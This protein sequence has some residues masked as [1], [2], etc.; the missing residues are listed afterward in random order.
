M[1]R[2]KWSSL[3]ENECGPSLPQAVVA[4]GSALVMLLI[5]Q[6]ELPPPPLP[7]PAGCRPAQ[8]KTERVPTT[9]LVTLVSTDWGMSWQYRSSVALAPPENTARV[10]S[11]GGD[12]P[13]CAPV[14]PKDDVCASAAPRTCVRATC[15]PT[16]KAC[17]VCDRG[18][19]V[20]GEVRYI[21][22]YPPVLVGEG[23][24][25]GTAG[26]ALFQPQLHALVD[27]LPVNSSSKVQPNM[28]LVVRA[29]TGKD[30]NLTRSFL[31]A[32]GSGELWKEV[33][34]NPWNLSTNVS[35][36]PA[37][38]DPASYLVC[39]SWGANGTTVCADRRLQ[40]NVSFDVK[41]ASAAQALHKERS[42][43]LRAGSFQ[44]VPSVRHGITGVMLVSALNVSVDMSA[45]N[46]NMTA[47]HTI[48]PVL[49]GRGNAQFFSAELHGTPAAADKNGSLIQLLTVSWDLQLSTCLHS[50]NKYCLAKWQE[51]LTYGA[52][53][54][55]ACSRCLADHMQELVVAGCNDTDAA[56]FCSTP[57]PPA[58]GQSHVV[59][60]VSTKGGRHWTFRAHIPPFFGF[61]ASAPNSGLPF[62]MA[63][64][65]NFAPWTCSLK[66]VAADVTAVDVGADSLLLF[67]VWQPT[68]MQHLP[69]GAMCGARSRDGG[70][71][72]QATDQLRIRR[73]DAA[74]GSNQNAP[75]HAEGGPP[76]LTSLG[77][78]GG[79]ALTDGMCGQGHDANGKPGAGLWLW[80]TSALGVNSSHNAT[81]S[82]EGTN[83]ALLHNIGLTQGI[84]NG[85]KEFIERSS[86]TWDFVNGTSDAS[87]SSGET[88]IYLLR[89]N[90]THAEVLV[91]YDRL[92]G[93]GWNG[94][95][96]QV[97]AMRLVISSDVPYAKPCEPKCKKGTICTHPGPEGPGVTPYGQPGTCVAL[98]VCKKPA[99][100]KSQT[101]DERTGHCVTP[102]PPPPQSCLGPIAATITRMSANASDPNGNLLA[103]WQP[104]TGR[105]PFEVSMCRAVSQDGA[106]TWQFYH[107][108]NNGKDYALSSVHSF[109]ISPQVAFA[110]TAAAGAPDGDGMV[111]MTQGQASAFGIGLSLWVSRVSH[112]TGVEIAAS[113]GLRSNVAG[114]TITWADSLSNLAEMHNDGVALNATE[115]EFTN[116]FVDGHVDPGEGG[117]ITD[118]HV[119]RSNT[120]HIELIAIYVKNKGEFL[121][122][123]YDHIGFPVKVVQNN[124]ILFAMHLTV[125]LV[126]PQQPKPISQLKYLTWYDSYSE[127]QMHLTA[128]GPN[129]IWHAGDP[130]VLHDQATQLGV[131]ALWAFNEYCQPGF[132]IFSEPYCGED[133]VYCMANSSKY[134]AI[135]PFGKACPGGKACPKPGAPCRCSM[136]PTQLALNWTTSVQNVAALLTDKP[137]IV[138]LW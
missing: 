124:S 4:D 38:E 86:F 87:Q 16:C 60:I 72:W 43:F 99:C 29:R 85:Y 113:T 8:K 71:T 83:L 41:G 121:P 130:A 74:D 22:A 136:S 114:G 100:K 15:E 64:A 55:G 14:C 10:Q 30:G 17:E 44:L 1:I 78:L 70:A 6:F 133:R 35:K 75:P 58:P 79:V 40:R 82:L 91:V 116:G 90:K 49:P 32:D 53:E 89:S 73:T 24:I 123:W 23:D 117:S 128:P 52:R 77:V 127:E 39:F 5:G 21:T 115:L 76:R 42:G 46:S 31:S 95:Q 63:I 2:F 36:L 33:A 12:E 108:I 104:T 105:K 26:H 51:E 56:V 98:K 18:A 126:L 119:L 25:N 112:E 80:T 125:S 7:P 84:H 81:P 120:S 54:A 68:Q 111:V 118:I 65:D 62:G 20:P 107:T 96:T 122:N 94:T 137:R 57:G 132:K 67:A 50:Q 131:S 3:Q 47:G 97:W 92:T 19:C 135:C 134:P 48:A 101:C 9:S 34:W 109:G 61:N 138:G 13:V 11:D 27:Q 102:P 103:V 106:R 45:A 37:A 88:D 28:T 66:P 59:A 69:S 93:A 110:P 129:L